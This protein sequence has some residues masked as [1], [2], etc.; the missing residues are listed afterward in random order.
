ME[1]APGKF[2]NWGNLGDAYRRAA[3]EKE[4]ALG[5]YSKAIQLVRET[6][7]LNEQDMDARASLAMYLA[8]TGDTNAALAEIR[9]LAGTAVKD[10][11]TTFKTALVFELAQQRE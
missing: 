1:L 2:L 4:K 6:L 8:K 7:A 3:G 9:Q 5:A 11:G 10:P